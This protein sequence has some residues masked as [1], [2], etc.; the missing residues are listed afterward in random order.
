[1]EISATQAIGLIT[2]ALGF[3][4]ALGKA[5]QN[6][7]RNTEVIKSL[8]KVI[9]PQD[10]ENCIITVS[11]CK[12]RGK[13]RSDL[14]DMKMAGTTEDIKEI[15]DGLRQLFDIVREVSVELAVLNANLETV[16]R[17]GH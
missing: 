14:F 7:K 8:Q 15:K 17:D 1:M 2:P 10:P 5:F 6:I 4:I 13:A 3:A 12:E 16:R 9:T 11:M